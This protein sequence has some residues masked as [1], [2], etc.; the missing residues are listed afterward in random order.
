MLSHL[1][2]HGLL[3]TRLLCPWNFPGKNTGVGRPFLLQGNLPDTGIK[4]TLACPALAGE[5]FT[6]VLSGNPEF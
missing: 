2:D 4:K 6:T 3:S 5:F 1:Q